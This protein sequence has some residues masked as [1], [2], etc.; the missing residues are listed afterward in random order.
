[1]NADDKIDG[2]D[3]VQYHKENSTEYSDDDEN[4]IAY[5]LKHTTKKQY[6]EKIGKI[7]EINI[8]TSKE[9]VKIRERMNFGD[10]WTTPN[11]LANSGLKNYWIQSEKNNKILVVTEKG[12]FN[13]S[14]PNKT[15]YVRPT[16]VI[17]K[18]LVTKVEEK[19]NINVDLINGLKRK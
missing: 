15:K 17:K 13:L 6:E 7:K 19:S 5:L 9:Y 11:W 14:D 10:E 3:M 1:M 18:E 12:T 4:S 8:I 2:G 16:I